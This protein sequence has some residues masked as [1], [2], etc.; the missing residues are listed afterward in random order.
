MFDKKKQRHN[1]NTYVID[2]RTVLS[3][4]DNLCK[5]NVTVVFSLHFSHFNQTYDTKYMSI[6]EQVLVLLKV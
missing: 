4:M 6:T 5:H 2:L 3:P 1:T